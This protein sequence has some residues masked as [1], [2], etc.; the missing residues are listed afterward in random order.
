MSNHHYKPL[1]PGRLFVGG[2]DAIDTL[3]E[4][5]EIDTIY[6][7]TEMTK[8]VYKSHVKLDQQGKKQGEF[9][10]YRNSKL[11][12]V[13]HFKNNNLISPIDYFNESGVNIFSVLLYTEFKLN[14]LNAK[15]EYYFE[16]GVATYS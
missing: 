13:C 12:T 4:N 11:F 15:A 7:K 14:E 5:E 9:R 1:I 10:Q 16:K 3:L 8:P 2:V 6:L